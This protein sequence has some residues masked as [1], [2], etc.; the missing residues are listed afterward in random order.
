[1]GHSSWFEFANMD[2]IFKYYITSGPGTQQLLNVS[3][4]TV[5][6]SSYPGYLES[7]DDFW[8]WMRAHRLVRA[9]A[10]PTP[11]IPRVMG[12]PPS[13]TSTKVS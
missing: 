5:A 12:A 11:R 2:R 6:F 1:M 10:R 13:N 3:S 9:W 7:L 8:A 4:R